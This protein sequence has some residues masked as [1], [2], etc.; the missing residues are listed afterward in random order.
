VLCLLSV[1]PLSTTTYVYHGGPYSPGGEKYWQNIWRHNER[2][3]LAARV[4]QAIA[5]LAVIPVSTAVCV[6]AAAVFAQRNK[7]TL[8]QLL[9]LADRGYASPRLY[10]RMVIKGVKWARRNGSGFWACATALHVVGAAIWPIQAGVVSPRVIKVQ[11]GSSSFRGLV[12]LASFDATSVRARHAEDVALQAGRAMQ[13]YEWDH[14]A[15]QLWAGDACTR[16]DMSSNCSAEPSLERWKEMPDP[17]FAQMPASS[18]TGVRREFVPR[19]NFTTDFTCLN[20]SSREWPAEC[21]DEQALLFEY[22]GQWMRSDHLGWSIRVCMP[23]GSTNSP[24]KP[25]RGRQDFTETLY[26]NA[27]NGMPGD[28]DACIAKIELKTTAGMFE[29]PNYMN[30][31]QPGPLLAKD[32]ISTHKAAKR[33]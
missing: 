4:L 3:Y 17:F 9:C 15:P 31:G 22:R 2:W 12:D 16:D 27:T 1:K 30:D 19:V 21:D 24:W 10:Q 20:R 8:K 23:P 18:N 28:D 6:H 11:R 25:T 5:G 14:S 7:I 13:G 32:P 26:I 29:M 33:E